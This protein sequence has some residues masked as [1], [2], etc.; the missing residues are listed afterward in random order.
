L[1]RQEIQVRLDRQALLGYPDSL[2]L[3][4]IKDLKVHRDLVGRLERQGL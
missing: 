1:A 3:L 4:E 2:V